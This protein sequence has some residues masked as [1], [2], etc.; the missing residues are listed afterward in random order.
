MIH[1]HMHVSLC[2]VDSCSQSVRR[3]LVRALPSSY[4]PHAAM[5][6]LMEDESDMLESSL[7]SMDWLPRVSTG[8]T[9]VSC[10]VFSSFA[11]FHGWR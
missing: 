3:L 6:D 7:T 8:A 4:W 11:S 2:D 5:D 10:P 1:V 9:Y